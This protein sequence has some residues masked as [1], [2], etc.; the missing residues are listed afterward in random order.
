MTAPSALPTPAPMPTAT[1]V[2]VA[3]FVAPTPV[4]VLPMPNPIAELTRQFSQLALA[5][6]AHMQ[7]RPSAANAPSVSALAPRPPRCM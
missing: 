7:P 1:P 2:Q 3:T 6:Q 5:M 4:P